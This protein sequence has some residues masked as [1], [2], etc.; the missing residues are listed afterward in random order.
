MYQNTKP[1]P[2]IQ[3]NKIKVGN[4]MGEKIIRPGIIQRIFELT[5]SKG[6]KYGKDEIS[7]ILTAFFDVTETELSKGNSVV[8]KGC[9]I[10]EPIHMKEKTI[11]CANQNSKPYSLLYAPCSNSFST[12]FQPFQ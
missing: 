2:Y 3:S 7:N 6:Q 1:P 9:M 8:L 4:G 10:V 11:Y 12:H 5:Q